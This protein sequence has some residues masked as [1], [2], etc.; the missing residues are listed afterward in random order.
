MI[1]LIAFLTL[2][3]V[4]QAADTLCEGCDGCKCYEPTTNCQLEEGNPCC[5]L[6]DPVYE[7]EEDGNDYT[8]VGGNISSACCPA[9]T[10]ACGG[11]FSSQ[12]RQDC[13][14][15]G[16]LLWVPPACCG[17]D[18][19]CFIDG[20]EPP[21]CVVKTDEPTF[22][23]VTLDPTTQS[24]TN[25][26]TVAPTTAAPS[27]TPTNS[28]TDVP[29]NAP[30]DAPTEVPTTAPTTSPTPAPTGPPTHAPTNAPTV[31]PTTA[32]PTTAPT[33]S[34]TGAPTFLS[35]LCPG[36]YQ[37]LR[38]KTSPY[39][40]STCGNYEACPTGSFCQFTAM[41]RSYCCFGSYQPASMA[42]VCLGLNCT[43]CAGN[44]CSYYGVHGCRK[45]NA[46]YAGIDQC[47]AKPTSGNIDTGVPGRCNR[48]CGS[49]GPARYSR[50]VSV[51]PAEVS[52]LE[53]EAAKAAQA[54]KMT[55]FTPWIG[56]YLP[57]P[58]PPPPRP[59][60]QWE[61]PCSCDD[62]CIENADCC[63]NYQSL[64]AVV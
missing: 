34:P 53:K 7:N 28:P 51:E 60:S 15:I 11:S 17:P 32:A 2:V 35:A 20:E 12:R 50:R 25:A 42:D 45:T 59:Q 31:A 62:K 36:G 41:S 6:A 63:A 54:E 55:F 27:T 64:C 56:N 8:V 13:T 18:Q 21:V 24:P 58:P 19:A 39:E 9:D 5:N 48:R 23:P 52:I 37:G 40:L 49:I 43:A 57:R 46:D 3:V 29:T 38:K 30:N 47:S 4:G 22:T 1:R 10:K 16:C 26:P 33:N 44:G 14:G 61:G